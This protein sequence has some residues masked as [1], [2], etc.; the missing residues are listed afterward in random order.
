V[1]LGQV[2]AYLLVDDLLLTSPDGEYLQD[3]LDGYWDSGS[4]N[5]LEDF[6]TGER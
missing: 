3:V 1:D 5:E 4:G 2:Q 6:R